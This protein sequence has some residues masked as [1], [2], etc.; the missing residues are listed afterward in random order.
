[1]RIISYRNKARLK[2]AV[3]IAA[4]AVLA[5]AVVCVA[6]VAYLSRYM[7]Y[8][9]DGAYLAL[10]GEE[11]AQGDSLP[12][13]VPAVSGEYVV[14]DRIERPQTEP[15]APTQADEP[16]ET[17]ALFTD[18][19]YATNAA[20]LQASDVRSALDAILAARDETDGT[21]AVL[22]DL[23]S[24]FGNFYYSTGVSGAPIASVDVGTIDALIAML[25]ARSDVY[26]IARLPA[27]RDTAYALSEMDQALALSSG[28]LWA[29]SDGC[30]WLDPGNEAVIDRLLAICS[31]LAARGVDE[32]TFQDFCFP[33]SENIVYEDDRSAAVEAA[34]KRLANEAALPVSFSF[35]GDE[36]SFESASY[37]R[38]ICLEAG[39]G[40]AI[41]SALA[42]VSDAL[43]GDGA[44][45]I[46]LSASRDTRFDEYIHLRPAVE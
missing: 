26:L 24:E 3:L 20:L 5:L 11:D 39:D 46:F 44:Q 21:I 7:V 30:Y 13:A 38:H 43:T 15:A 34:A 6:Y 4:F 27:F 1:M 8:T 41:A 29:D 32:V 33:S 10:P 28:A 14:G 40:A 35:S 37:G 25:A 19:Y 31:D 17:T 36:P 2:R 9:S 23:K 12:D 22:L 42:N 45:I 16:A 18:G